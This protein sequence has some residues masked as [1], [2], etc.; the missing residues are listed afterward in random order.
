MAKRDSLIQRR[1]SRVP[2]RGV[3]GY[4]CEVRTRGRMD[5]TVETYGV[6]FGGFV[7]FSV[8]LPSYL[9]TA[10]GLERGDAGWAASSRRW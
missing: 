2:G 9:S 5:E 10:Y 7:A 8:Y 1:R 6:A 4:G 3:F